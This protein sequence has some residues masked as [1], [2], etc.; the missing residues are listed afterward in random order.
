MEEK[1]VS[2]KKRENLIIENRERLTA[3]G[4]CDVEAFTT[5]KIVL[6]TQSGT[7][8]VTGKNMRIK[9]LNSESMD[10]IIE[11]KIDGSVYTDGKTEKESFLKRVLK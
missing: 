11:G 7:L 2:T 5:E 4:I 1:Q 3:S 8:T 10:A 9:K 6:L